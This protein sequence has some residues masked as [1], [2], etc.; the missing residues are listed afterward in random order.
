MYYLGPC[1]GAGSMPELLVLR[2]Q[3]GEIV[4][5]NVEAMSVCGSVVRGPAYD[6]MHPLDLSAQGWTSN[7]WR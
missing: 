1:Q 3:Q 4:R 5:N 6:S 7:G 2:V